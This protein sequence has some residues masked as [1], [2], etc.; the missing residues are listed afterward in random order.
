V[1][2][3]FCTS[4]LGGI[5]PFQIFSGNLISCGFDAFLLLFLSE[6]ERIKGGIKRILFAPFLYSTQQYEHMACIRAL[7][8]TVSC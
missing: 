7:N 1:L 4:I 3:W 8:G 6:E 5:V 2:L